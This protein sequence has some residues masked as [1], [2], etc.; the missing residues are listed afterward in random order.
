MPF[1]KMPDDTGILEH[2]EISASLTHP[3]VNKS[4]YV[5]FSGP[6]VSKPEGLAQLRFTNPIAII[7]RTLQITFTHILIFRMGRGDL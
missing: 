1:Q 3:P 7:A 6:F 2:F 5:S 4:A